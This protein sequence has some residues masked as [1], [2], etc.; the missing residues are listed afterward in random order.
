MEAEERERKKQDANCNRGEV[1]GIGMRGVSGSVCMRV[2]QPCAGVGCVPEGEPA[3][4][5]EM[6]MLVPSVLATVHIVLDV[7]NLW[8]KD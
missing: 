6:H 3:M 7:S 8:P 1:E 2:S 4:C 5:R